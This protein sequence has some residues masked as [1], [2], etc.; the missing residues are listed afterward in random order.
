MIRIRMVVVFVGLLI[1]VGGCS[2]LRGTTASGPPLHYVGSS[3][4]AIFVR[5][6]EPVY[7]KVRFVIDSAPESAGGEVTSSPGKAGGIQVNRSKR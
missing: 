1:A 6:A 4:V 5:D 2:A 7:G 3:T